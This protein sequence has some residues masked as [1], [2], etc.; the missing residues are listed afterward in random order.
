MNKGKFTMSK[1]LMNDLLE[2]FEKHLNKKVAVAF[3]FTVE[4]DYKEVHWAMNVSRKDGV[5]LFQK[6]AKKIISQNN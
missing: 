2:V 3:A 1:D 6:T 5:M 4:P